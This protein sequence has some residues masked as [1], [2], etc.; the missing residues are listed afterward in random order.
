[1]SGPQSEGSHQIGC[2]HSGF[3]GYPQIPN[4]PR[5]LGRSKRSHA[6]QHPRDDSVL[7]K[8]QTKVFNLIAPGRWVKSKV[9][10]AKGEHLCTERMSTHHPFQLLAGIAPKHVREWAPTSIEEP[11]HE[12]QL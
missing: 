10:R 3:H 7:I 2:R 12:L 6:S 5:F 1:M 9:R 11:R 4:S 8:A